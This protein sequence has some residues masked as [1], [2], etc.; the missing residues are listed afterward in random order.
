MISA[1][2]RR[3]PR[4]DRVP[5]L[6]HLPPSRHRDGRRALRRRRRAAVRARG[7]PRR[8]AAR[9]RAGRHL[10]AHRPARRRREARGRRRGAPGLRLPLRERRL[11]PRR[12]RRRPD[13]GRPD[14]ESIE[15]MGSKIEAK[16]IMREAGVPVLE[17]PDEP[18]EAGPAPAGQGVGRWRR[19]RHA[20]R[21]PSRGP[22]RRD[23]RRGGRGAVGVRRR[24]GVRRAVR[25]AGP[26]RRGAGV[27][28][29]KDGCS[30]WA[31]ATARSSAA[32][33]RSSRSRRLPGWPGRVREALHD[34]GRRAAEAIDYRGA[35]TVEFLYDAGVRRGSGSWR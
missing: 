17:A 33:R 21:P 13:L 32:T 15:A 18:T 1:P 19:P 2:A 26:P 3:Q 28:D 10:P 22:R 27:G 5:R 29:G 9:Q 23:R 25:R 30:S 12:H 7:R 35:G 8:T 24:H 4:G 34:A 16:R 14:P 31:S 20:R 6:P 11:R